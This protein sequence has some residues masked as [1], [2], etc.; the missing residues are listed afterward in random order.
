MA[1]ILYF[2]NDWNAENRTSS[3]HIARRLAKLHDVYYI[4]CPGMRAPQA[5]GRDFRRIVQKLW[6]SLRGPRAVMPG[7]KV[8]TLVQVPLHR[9][10]LVRWLNA[11]LIYWS[12]RWLMWR[13]GIRRPIAWFVAPHVA[14]LVGRLDESL[15]VYYVTDDHASMPGMDRE[16]MRRM[17]ERL[18][19]GA[20]LVFV[21]SDT[22]LEAKTAINPHTH[23]SPHGVDL[24]HFGRACD[25]AGR[26]PDDVQGLRQPIV[27]F[28]GLVERWIDLDLVRYLAEQRPHWTFLMI[29]RVAVAPERVPQLANVHFIGKRA[30]EELP[31]YGRAFTAAILPFTLTPEAWHANPLKLLEY[32]AMGRPVVSVAIPAAERLGDVIQVAHNRDE[33]LA[34]LDEAVR[35]ASNPEAVERRLRRAAAASW[36]SRVAEV[37][38]LVQARLEEKAA[39]VA[40]VPAAPKAG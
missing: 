33:F 3:H 14:S 39:G 21:A 2:G 11:R 5:S 13:Q 6:R 29:G 16:S 4:E 7:L 19:R 38:A 8:Q 23:Y 10:A 18:T 35:Q 34:G 37:L 40:A 30:Y 31:D 12:V 20:D 9:F 26:V 36:D 22:L 17:D 15:S 27:G 28:F 1:T 24:E 32:L 25:P